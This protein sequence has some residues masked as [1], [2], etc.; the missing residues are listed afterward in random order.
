MN[1]SNSEATELFGQLR[2]RVTGAGFGPADADAAAALNEYAAGGLTPLTAFKVY[3]GA[4]QEYLQAHSIGHHEKVTA[5][6][7]GGLSGGKIEKIV[8]RLPA[9]LFGERDADLREIAYDDRRMAQFTA[10]AEE[11]VNFIVNSTSSHRLPDLPN[12]DKK[13]EIDGPENPL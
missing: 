4:I 2:E 7:N 13:R 6:L 9:S 10:A 12:K 3:L 5:W 11:L 1:I 8:V